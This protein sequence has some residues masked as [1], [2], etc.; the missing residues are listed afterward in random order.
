VGTHR[1]NFLNPS[2]RILPRRTL[3][4][5]SVRKGFIASEIEQ[6][7]FLEIRSNIEMSISSGDFIILFSLPEKKKI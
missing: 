2:A 7:C 4:E 5:R 6:P 1:I 3:S